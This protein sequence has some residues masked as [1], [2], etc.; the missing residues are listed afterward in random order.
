MG[1]HSRAPL[2][3]S[4]AVDSK[5]VVSANCIIARTE[6]T[7]KRGAI[8]PLTHAVTQALR[9]HIYSIENDVVSTGTEVFV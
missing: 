7:T 4:D 1:T 2:A 6:R 9:E 5:I 8:A 3:L